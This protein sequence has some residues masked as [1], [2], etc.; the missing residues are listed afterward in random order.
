MVIVVLH[1]AV[2]V[3]GLARLRL[4]VAAVCWQ[5]L[6]WWGT[7]MSACV[8]W[9]WKRLARLVSALHAASPFVKT[10]ARCLLPP[11]MPAHR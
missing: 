7:W 2:L 5:A 3:L 1:Q 6:A 9:G 11:L 10:G 8:A 4:G